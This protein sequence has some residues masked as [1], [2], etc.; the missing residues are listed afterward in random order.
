MQQPTA[1]SPNRDDNPVPSETQS[2]ESSLSASQDTMQVQD[3]DS[4]RKIERDSVKLPII[5]H[6]ETQ[7]YD[8]VALCSGVVE[9][10]HYDSIISGHKETLNMSPKQKT[11]TPR[12]DTKSPEKDSL[13]KCKVLYKGP[14]DNRTASERRTDTLQDSRFD[15]NSPQHPTYLGTMP[16]SGRERTGERVAQL[17]VLGSQTPS[18]TVREREADALL[19]GTV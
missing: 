17:K 18:G 9:P 19:L 4:S 2:S 5:E 7:R 8:V 12:T 11:K 1:T 13:V 15:T 10:E 3:L 6:G 14:N 16:E